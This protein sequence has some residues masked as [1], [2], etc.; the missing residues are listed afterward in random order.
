MENVSLNLRNQKYSHTLSL[1]KYIQTM[2][3]CVD[4]SKS[5]QQKK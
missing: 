1:L 3:A 4:M 2:Q 5:K